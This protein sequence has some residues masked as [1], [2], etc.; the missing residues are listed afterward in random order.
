LKL[1]TILQGGT[2][3]VGTP[4]GKASSGTANSFLDAYIQIDPTWA[5]ANPGYTL[6]MDST[7]GVSPVPMPGSSRMMLAGLACLIGIQWV[8][9][10]AS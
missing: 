3:G 4:S 8:R 6:V 10:V 2:R 7:I 9:R 1:A 5:Q